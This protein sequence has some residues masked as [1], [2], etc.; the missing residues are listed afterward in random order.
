MSDG[1]GGCDGCCFCRRHFPIIDTNPSPNPCY[2]QCLGEFLHR[3][4]GVLGEL[5]QGVAVGALKHLGLG[6]GRELGLL[7][8]KR[9]RARVLARSG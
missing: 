7:G 2:G 9:A 1:C 8:K 4:A 6:S 5:T 3:S